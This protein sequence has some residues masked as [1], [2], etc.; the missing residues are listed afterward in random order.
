M[1]ATAS[2]ESPFMPTALVRC[3]SIAS[4]IGALSGFEAVTAVTAAA[5]GAAG[6]AARRHVSKPGVHLRKP[7]RIGAEARRGT[8]RARKDEVVGAASRP[9]PDAFRA[10]DGESDYGFAIRA[11]DA[12]GPPAP[13]P[14]GKT[15]RWPNK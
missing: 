11:E 10:E 5:A 12:I 3:L 2:I 14:A 7:Q 9:A 4:L 1:A 6:E 15:S 8:A 13:S